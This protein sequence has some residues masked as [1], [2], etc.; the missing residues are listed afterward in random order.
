MLA[1][2]Y[3]FLEPDSQLLAEPAPPFF[4][5]DAWRVRAETFFSPSERASA[6]SYF[7]QRRIALLER[8]A[9]PKMIFLLDIAFCL[10]PSLCSCQHFCERSQRRRA[11]PVLLILYSNVPRPEERRSS[12]PKR[13]SRLRYVQV[14]RRGNKSISFPISL[15]FSHWSPASASTDNVRIFNLL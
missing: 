11:T 15:G 13:R 7:S 4:G 9:N 14:D 1:M 8:I 10:P 12:N 6:A 2:S 3:R 5:S